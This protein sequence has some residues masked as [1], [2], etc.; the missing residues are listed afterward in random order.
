M[1]DC[2]L[3]VTFTCKLRLTSI[4]HSKIKVRII[5]IIVYIEDVKYRLNITVD[6][7]DQKVGAVKADIFI[8]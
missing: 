5:Q 1:T 8:W 2:Q 6:M 3:I 7:L 4:S